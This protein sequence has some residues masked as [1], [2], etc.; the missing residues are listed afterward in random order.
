MDEPQIHADERRS[1]ISVHLRES[2]AKQSS[3]L[4][5]HNAMKRALYEEKYKESSEN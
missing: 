1:I 2:A 4:R 3:G 5:E